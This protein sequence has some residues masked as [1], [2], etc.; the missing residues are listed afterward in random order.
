MTKIKI[1][2]I[3]KVEEI[4]YLNNEH[5]DYAGFVIY[6]NSKR[7]ITVERAVAIA[8][9][10]NPDIKKV[11]VCVSPDVELLKEIEN[12]GFDIIQVHKG[13][14]NAVID[15]S[16]IPIWY[17]VNALDTGHA[18][19][20]MEW[21]HQLPIRLGTKIEAIV[22]D[23]PDFG[24]GKTFDWHKS[25]RLLKAGTLSPPS[26]DKLFTKKFVLAGGLDAENVAEGINIFKPDI[27]DVSSSVEGES[28]KDKDKI[29]AFVNAVRSIEQ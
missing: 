5:V 15:A 2:G 7:Y 17:A 28:G 4:E 19:M 14:S 12:G 1:C 11:A 13:L 22:M 16:S 27:V 9:S 21:I 8:E 6:K 25:K 26:E 10:L 20:T 3:T 18:A 29:S 23:A 24:S